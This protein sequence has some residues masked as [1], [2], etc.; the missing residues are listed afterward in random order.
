MSTIDDLNLSVSDMTNE[1]LIERLR[2]MRQSRRTHK[3]PVKRTV[4]AAKPIELN[5]AN[6]SEDQAAN[7][8]AEL[9]G[10]MKS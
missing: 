9:E 2:V 10:M 7:L 6:L 1:E 8:I 5:P 3:A 4:K